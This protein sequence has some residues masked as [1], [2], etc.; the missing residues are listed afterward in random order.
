VKPTII[1]PC[2]AA[3][4]AAGGRIFASTQARGCVQSGIH[5]FH[6]RV[7]GNGGVTLPMLLRQVERWVEE[8][9]PAE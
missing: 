1:L 8:T 7:L 6:D 3:S 2:A 4:P 9:G 5:E